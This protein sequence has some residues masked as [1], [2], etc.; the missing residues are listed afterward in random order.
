MVPLIHSR[1]EVVVAPVSPPLLEAGD[2]V[3]CK[4]AGSIYLH[5]VKAVDPTRR[6][7]QIGNN[8]GGING[9]TGFDRVYGIVVSVASVA[10]PGAGAKVAPPTGRPDARR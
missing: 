5:L 10:R 7:A 6:R 8:R 4:V 1:D 3:L 9:W 2:I